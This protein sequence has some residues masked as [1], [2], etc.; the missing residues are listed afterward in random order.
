MINKLGGASVLAM[1]LLVPMSVKAQAA[2][3]SYPNKPV[4]ILVGYPAGGPTDLT[5]RM[6]AAKLQASMGQ[7]FVIDNKPGAGS[8]V[9][10]EMLAT[11]PADG[12]TLMI[13]AAQLTWNSV[14]YKNIRYDAIK[15]FEP[16][17]R[18]MSAPAVLAVNPAKVNA[19]TVSELV[20]QAKKEPGKYTFASSGPGSV[21]HIAGELLKSKAKIDLLHVPYK[22]SGPAVNAVLGGE[23]DMYFMTVLSSMPYFKSGKL[24]PIAVTSNHRI[25]QLPDVPTMAEAGVAGVEI[26]SWN[27]LFAPAGT[28]KEIVEKLGKEV[29]KVMEMP[30]VRKAFEE[31]GATVVGSTPAEFSAYL[32]KE[33]SL[34]TT[35]A[36]SINLKLD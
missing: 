7:S 10:S 3:P 21:P 25:P 28:P 4:R 23:T 22:G 2:A 5:A 15:S 13:A 24:R 36:R 14:L 31:Q 26:D 18:L 19:K 27:G 9:A 6:I 12:Y 16:I 34:G 29:R 20:A 8:N 35:F 1:A 33:V 17:S 11:S 30:D 32:K